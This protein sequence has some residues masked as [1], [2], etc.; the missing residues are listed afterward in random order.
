M[1]VSEV[2]GQDALIFARSI[3][4]LARQV[5]LALRGPVV[6]ED[7]GRLLD[8]IDGLAAE[9]KVRQSDELG[10]WLASLRRIV[11]EQTYATV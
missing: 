4:V 9:A 6:V 2:S 7:F 10:R 3:R 11:E 1:S 8:R 5:R